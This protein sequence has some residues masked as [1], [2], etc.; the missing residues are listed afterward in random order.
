MDLFLFFLKDF[1]LFER[2][3]AGER[4]SRGEEQER[5]KQVPR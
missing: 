5:E 1:Y 3:R 4:A 2:E